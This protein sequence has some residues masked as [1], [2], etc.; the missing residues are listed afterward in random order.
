MKYK[1]YNCNSFNIYTI[2][3]DK[4]KTSHMEVIFRNIAKKE[5]MGKY[6]FLADM[7]SESCKMYPRKKDLI[8]RFEELYKI[9]IYASTVRVGNVL[10]LLILFILMMKIMWRKLLKLYLK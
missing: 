2:K 5:E 6:S 3:T 9:I 4:F 10:I 1:T 8:T 7:M